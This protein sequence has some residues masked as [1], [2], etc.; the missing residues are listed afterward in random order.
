[1]PFL[2]HAPGWFE[3]GERVEGMSNHTD[4]LPT[5]VEMLGYEIRGGEYPGHSLLHPLPG[6]RTLTFSCFHEK[7]CLA[8]IEGSEKYIYHYGNQPDEVFDLSEDP[9]EREN[10]AGERGQDEMDERREALLEWRSNVNAAY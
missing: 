5:V 6:Q 8:S 1:V 10:L 9:L 3:D 4:V 2:I 7:A